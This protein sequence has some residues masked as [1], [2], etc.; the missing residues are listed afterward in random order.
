MNDQSINPSQKNHTVVIREASQ[1]RWL[2]FQHPE[3]VISIHRINEVLPA[4]QEIE[5]IVSKDKYY[6]A[7]W[8]A[9]EAAPAFDVAMTVKQNDSFPLLWFGIYKKPTAIEWTNQN[10]GQIAQSQNWEPSI[11]RESYQKAIQKIKAYLKNGDTY[12][13]NFTFRLRSTFRE[14]PWSYFKKLTV[15][16][17]TKYGS[18]INTD[19]WA[20]CS[21]SPELFFQLN[22]KE[23]VSRP[24]KGTISRRFALPTGWLL[25]PNPCSSASWRP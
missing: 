7:G 4:L 15:L 1:K 3:L 23:L 2:Y 19:N 24:M 16:Q 17:D 18:F 22:E 25:T 21:I 6:A 13:V 20:V 12:Q 8:I 11:S 10:S 14:D 9:Y 5:N